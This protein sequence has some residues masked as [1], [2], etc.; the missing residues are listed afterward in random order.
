MVNA[1]HHLSGKSYMVKNG[2]LTQ[3]ELDNVMS[4]GYPI[5]VGFYWH[6]QDIAHVTTLAGC[7]ADGKYLLHDSD[8]GDAGSYV[9][10]DYHDVLY[11]A[12]A[13]GVPDDWRGKWYLTVYPSG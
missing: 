3:P 4:A 10:Y 12:T 9:A 6:H 13:P 11:Y 5:I 1:I 8:N 2:P 7:S